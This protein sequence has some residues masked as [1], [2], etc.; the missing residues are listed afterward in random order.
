M[1]FKN[2]FR[3]FIM[4]GLVAAIIV[5]A[6][7]KPDYSFSIQPATNVLTVSGEGVVTVMPDKAE[8]Y[9]NVFTEAVTAEEAKDLNAEITD[10]VYRALKGADVDKDDIETSSFNLYPKM[11]WIQ[12]DEEYITVGYEVRHTIKVTTEEIDDVG[13]LIDVAVNAGAN[14]VNQVIF[15]LTDETKKEVE[16]QALT[17]ATEEAKSRAEAMATAAEV[18]LE[19]LVSISGNTGYTPYFRAAPEMAS[20]SS[21]DEYQKS[22][23]IMP[24]SLEIRASA[25]LVYEIE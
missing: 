25:S 15:D 12:D 17:K 1:E 21:G 18:K 11:K 16:K 2:M 9:I 3:G 5:M 4:I 20:L 22:T 23:N 13:N 10:E 19:K 7:I 6:A 8:L 24:E 14:G